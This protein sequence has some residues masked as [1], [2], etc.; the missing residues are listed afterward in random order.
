M[1]NVT[2][3]PKFSGVNIKETRYKDPEAEGGKQ[4]GWYTFEV[5]PRIARGV[6]FIDNDGE[7][8]STSSD[9]ADQLDVFMAGEKH[10][11]K[12]SNNP[13]AYERMAHKLSDY[14]Y[15]GSTSRDTVERIHKMMTSLANDANMPLPKKLELMGL[16]NTKA[17]KDKTPMDGEL[18]IDAPTNGRIHHWQ[19]LEFNYDFGEEDSPAAK[20]FL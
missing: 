6:H 15:G 2:H 12:P 10:L 4:G 3:T 18:R 17:E 16:I 8:S 9:V 11:R 14:L 19:G 7:K 1:L 13:V 20:P 5:S